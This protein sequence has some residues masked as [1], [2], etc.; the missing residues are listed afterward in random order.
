MSP[1][2]DW[3]YR[4]RGGVPS[5][6]TRFEDFD[7]GVVAKTLEVVSRVFGPGRYFDVSVQ[8]WHHLPSGPALLVSN[9]SGGTSIPDAWGFVSAWYRQQGVQRPL[10]A[11]AHEIVLANPFVGEFFAQHGILRGR[12]DLGLAALKQHRR[13]VLVMPGGD[14]D[15]WRPYKDRYRVCFGGRTGYAWLALKAGV[16]IIPVANAGAHETLM[17]LARGRRI[18]RALHLKQLARTEIFP[19]H[20]SLPWGLA[21]GPLPHLPPPT[22]LQYKL[23]APVQLQAGLE[24]QAEPSRA[25]VQALDRQV[26]AR[27]QG[28]LDR[29][30]DERSPETSLRPRAQAA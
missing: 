20:L 3:F 19:I 26:R 27:M 1:L 25:A 13:D 8:G 10:H 15:T 17:V 14:L 12:R 22:R 6:G 5:Y 28:L 7:P 9:H 21:V 2:I 4:N 23:G 16:P 24:P 11:M 30:R 29:L 18:A